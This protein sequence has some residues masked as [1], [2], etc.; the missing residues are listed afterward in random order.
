VGQLSHPLQLRTQFS[1]ARWSQ[2][3]GLFLSGGIVLLETLD[4][5]ILVWSK[6]SCG[7]G[8]DLEQSS[9]PLAT[10]NRV[11]ALLGFVGSIREKKLV[12][13]ALMIA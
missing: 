5:K 12:A 10:L 1:T 6:N 7:A 8:I 9:E 11:A 2:L 3:V 13:F 4:P